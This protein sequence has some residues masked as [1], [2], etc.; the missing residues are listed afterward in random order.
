MTTFVRSQEIEHDIGAAG[1][2]ALRVT[3]PDVE[4]TAAP[5]GTA[6]VV[7][8]FEIRATSDA[9]ANEI[10]ERFRYNVDAGEARLAVSEPK[11]EGG[12]GAL[13]RML[14]GEGRAAVARVTVTAPAGCTLDVEGVSGD[15]LSTGFTGRQ[16]YRTVSGDLVLDQ[17]AGELRVKGVSGDVSLRATASLP[18]LEIATVS[19]DA[20]VVA[21]SV[22]RASVTT[23]SGDVELETVLGSDADHRV[24]T[25]SGDLSFGTIGDLQLEVRGLSSDADVRFPHRVSGSRDRRRYAVGDG[26]PSVL[27]SSMSGDVEVRPARRLDEVPAPPEPPEPPTAPR[28]SPSP[29]EEMAPDLEILRALERGEIDVDEAARRLGDGVSR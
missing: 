13:A 8:T 28:T 3:T 27:F 22:G 6:R 25:V 7:V 19:G 2:L 14:L 26:G 24:E 5:G 12:I 4:L 9:D 29:G 20:S 15:V 21:P 23:V 10:L 18:L 1:E 17:V 16:R 11:H